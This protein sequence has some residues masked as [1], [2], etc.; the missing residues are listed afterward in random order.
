MSQ[1]LTVSSRPEGIANGDFRR[2]LERVIEQERG[3]RCTI[4]NFARRP[5]GQARTRG[6]EVLTVRLAAGG[7]MRLFVK[8]ASDARPSAGS[9]NRWDRERQVYGDLLAGAPLDTPRY[10]GSGWDARRE[11]SWL[12]LEFV[13]GDRL[14]WQDLDHF[15]AA[16]AWLGRMQVHF[17]RHP[18]RP[19]AC[20]LLDRHDASFFQGWADRARAAARGIAPSLA[21]RL[22]RLVERH[23]PWIEVMTAGPPTVVHG[24]FRRR[25]IL[26]ERGSH[27]PRIRPV[28][29]EWAALGSPLYDLAF[30]SEGVRP[31]TL[32]RMW[33]AYRDA[34]TASGLAAPD[35]ETIERLTACFRI[36]RVF[37]QLAEPP[38]ELLSPAEAGRLIQRAERLADALEEGVLYAR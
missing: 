13:S 16:A 26:V 8:L 19:R 4:A 2:C 18:D 23:E 24:S 9:G 5:V 10:H 20:A 33:T 7:S 3:T 22:L 29:W 6:P 11:R 27:P 34:R 37:R 30:L 21:G 36:H 14:R 15:V 38:A 32:E 35:W 17:G 12:L 31:P 25:H 28:G 1:S